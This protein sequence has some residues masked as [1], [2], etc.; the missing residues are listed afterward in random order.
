ML[1]ILRVF[2]TADQIAFFIIAAC[3]MLMILRVLI[4]ADQIAFLVV[5]GCT[6]L[7]RCPLSEAAD[8]MTFL[9]VAVQSVNMSHLMTADEF[10]FFIVAVFAVYV[11]HCSAVQCSDF[12][13][14][15]FHDFEALFRMY[16]LFQLKQSAGYPAS[17]DQIAVL[18]EAVLCVAAVIMHV[19]FLLTADQAFLCLIAFVRMSMAFFCLAGFLRRRLLRYRLLCCRFRFFCLSPIRPGC[20]L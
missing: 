9:V 13:R 7:V 3:I 11:E 15:Q 19:Q 20:G 4:A 8:Q 18:I 16:M 6:V 10:A 17:L 1:M 12:F 5:A 14:S 2:V